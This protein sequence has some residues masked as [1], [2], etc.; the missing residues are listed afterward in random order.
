M[1]VIIDID[2]K[3]LALARAV[4]LQAADDKEYEGAVEN[5]F[6]RCEG[7]KSIELNVND[8]GREEA[9][10]LSLGLA[11]IAISKMM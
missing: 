8:M 9:R 7:D 4:L 10:Q 2:K 11:L 5:A 1:K 3:S 6:S